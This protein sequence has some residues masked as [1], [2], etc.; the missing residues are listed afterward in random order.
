MP[1]KISGADFKKFYNDKKWWPDGIWHEEESISVN[2][3]E[4]DCY[5]TDYDKILDSDLLVISGGCV[6]SDKR[7][8]CSMET[9]IRRWK[10]ALAERIILV[11]APQ[12]KLGDIVGAIKGAGGKVIS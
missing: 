5:E 6:L 2:G 8:I 12:K 10:S 3:V 1:V 11:K 4:K 9:Y 7:E